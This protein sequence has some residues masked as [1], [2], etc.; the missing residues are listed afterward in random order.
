MP[1]DIMLKEAIEALEKGQRIRAK[2]LLARLLRA[3]QANP[4]YWLWMSSVVETRGERI[5]CLESVLRLDPNNQAAKRG[6]VLLGALPPEIVV[7]PV[8]P[9]RRK[10][11]AF[12]DEE[13]EV[14]LT[15]WQ[16]IR[17]NPF[18][19]TGV[20]A[21]VTL[22][23]IGMMIFGVFGMRSFYKDTDRIYRVSITPGTRQPTLTP[24]F[25]PT[26]TLVVRSPT[27]TY[28]GEMP[29]WML[30]E[31]T[32][33]PVPLYVNTP[34]PINEAYRAGI[35][36]Y[37]RGELASMLSFMLQASQMEPNSADTLYH[38]GEA[39]RLNGEIENALEAY[40]QSI[41]MS[42]GFAPA[43]LGRSRCLLLINANADV[44]ED[45]EQA[46]QNDPN[47]TDAY[48]ERANHLL[49]KG[50]LE[51]AL[52]DLK[53]AQ[54]LYP[55]SPLLNVLLAQV[56]L[57]MGENEIA[58]ERAHQAHKLDITLLPAYKTLALALL[59]NGEPLE[60]VEYL[61]IYL[62]YEP[63]QAE[64]WLALGK[65]HY[66][67]GDDYPAALKAF[68]RAFTLDRNLTEVYLHRGKTYI[69]MQEGQLATNELLM[70]MRLYPQNF[71][72]SLNL[73]RALLTADR[74]RD[75]FGQL[76]SAANLAETDA[77]RAALY[78]WRA[79]SAE[80]LGNLDTAI[81][82]WQALLNLPEEAVSLE[83]VRIAGER[84]LV[85]NPP[86]ATPTH[87]STSTPTPSRTPTRTPSSTATPTST[88]T[89]TITATPTHTRTPSSTPTL[90][91]TATSTPT[92]TR[93]MTP[94]LTRTP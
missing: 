49:H 71:E 28:V 84:L 44:S 76:N 48:L 29:L 92:Q 16:K 3:D 46:I 1:E 59:A 23:V 42:P 17:T 69:A 94:T 63:T 91:S 7:E 31:A 51:A 10:W 5:Y 37:N 87:T 38:L 22:F 54:E 88:R 27:P 11:G 20:F 68:D 89:P 60:A 25:F 56:Y 36:A 77:E 13:P 8:I 12:L 39:Y 65:A 52:E 47:L 67:G 90:K 21:S 35:R 40:E 24:T 79:L 75:A 93:S 14:Q 82:N 61:E 81:E 58:L 2:D 45:L 73:G 34:H 53:I 85:L 15:R 32:Y 9:I 41:K 18:L 62:R 55:E 50:D 26:K 4:D 33:T 74:A 83:W 66:L 80:A 19:R 86:T 64:V 78:Y 70:A 72:I 43:Y 57:G 6:M 30:L